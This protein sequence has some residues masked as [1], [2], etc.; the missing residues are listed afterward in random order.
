[1]IGRSMSGVKGVEGVGGD[2][3]YAFSLSSLAFAMSDM[4]A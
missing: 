4:A 1:M 2:G 3:A